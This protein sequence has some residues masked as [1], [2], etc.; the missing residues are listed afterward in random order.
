MNASREKP[1]NK[2]QS[3]ISVSY[4]VEMN[5]TYDGTRTLVVSA[6]LHA[7]FVCVCLGLLKVRNKTKSCVTSRWFRK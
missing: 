1:H 4:V 3:R 2:E 6:V 7:G 5:R